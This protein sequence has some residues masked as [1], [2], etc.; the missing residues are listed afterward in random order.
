MVDLRLSKG[1]HFDAEHECILFNVKRIPVTFHVHVAGDVRFVKGESS[2]HSTS[3]I[4]RLWHFNPLLCKMHLQFDKNHNVPMQV[5]IHLDSFIS[6]MS[7]WGC[8]F[9][10]GPTLTQ[11]VGS[12]P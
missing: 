9:A 5:Y 12:V 1:F 10:S 4:I 6:T 3:S 11:T 7:T 2:S 8:N